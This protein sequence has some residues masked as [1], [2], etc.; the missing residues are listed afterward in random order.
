MS[1]PTSPLRLLPTEATL[2]RVGLSPF[3]EDPR[4]FTAHYQQ[5]VHSR[6]L[7]PVSVLA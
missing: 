4:L 3:T 6:Q 1:L 7:K 2:V 5:S